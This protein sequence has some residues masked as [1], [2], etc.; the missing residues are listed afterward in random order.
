MNREIFQK[1][2]KSIIISGLVIIALLL[3]YLIGFWFF[4]TRFVPNTK[5]GDISIGQLSKPAARQRIQSELDSYQLY[6]GEQDESLGFIELAQLDVSAD[7]EA[8]LNEMMNAQSPAKWPLHLVVGPN[9]NVELETIVSF[10]SDTLS[11]LIGTIGIQNQ[12]RPPSEDAFIALNAEGVFQLHDEVY[13]QQVSAESLSSAIIKEVEQ[14]S[15][16]VDLAKAYI[17]PNINKDNEQLIAL[18]NKLEQ[19]QNVSLTLTFD[20]E[21][22]TIPK[23]VIA[24]WISI[25]G[26]EPVVETDLI[27]D[28]I[29]DLNKQYAGLFQQREFNSTYQG[30]VMLDPGTY[31]W[32]IDRLVEAERIK[33]DILAVRDVEREPTIGGSGYGLEDDI[34]SSYVEV[35]ILNQMM[36]IYIEGEIALQTAI[37]TGTPGTNTVAGTYQVWNKEY[38][39]TLVGYNP[40]TEK[41]YEQ[42]V[43]YWI[44]FDDQAQGIHDASW[45]GYFGGDAYLT[46]G[47]LGCVNTPPGVMP[48]VF[49]LVYHGMPVIVF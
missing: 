34:G 32:Y 4:Q 18:Q 7:T 35:D 31:G 5:L 33:E 24:S 11:S 49:E 45:Q 46:N 16:Q 29:L 14:G 43:D 40:V 22:V 39:T 20:G 13:G 30:S 1:Y 19:M 38:D 6:L 10:N 36:T 15:K 27:E 47:S 42:P 26:Q 9:H 2:R 28:Y 23:E 3:I 25:D 21:T 8:V 41:D 48:Q 12:A 17:K 44:A 37:V